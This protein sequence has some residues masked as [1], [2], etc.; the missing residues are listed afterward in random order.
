MNVVTFV[1]RSGLAWIGRVALAAVLTNTRLVIFLNVLAWVCSLLRLSSSDALSEN[2]FKFL[3]FESFVSLFSCL[4]SALVESSSRREMVATEAAITASRLERTGHGLLSLMCDAVFHVDENWRFEG[5]STSLSALL[6][7]DSGAS[8][9]CEL[10]ESLICDGDRDRFETFRVQFSESSP[11]QC[12][13]LQLRDST[14][15]KVKV[16]IFSYQLEGHHHVGIKEDTEREHEPQDDGMMFLPWQGSSRWRHHL[17]SSTTGKSNAPVR[18][19]IFD[20]QHQD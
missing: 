6:L 4:I 15:T 20:T 3:S 7:Q 5:H 8:F 10:F 18:R 16:E 12:V 17:S 9:R 11:A 2:L 13:H 19:R 14:R 1:V